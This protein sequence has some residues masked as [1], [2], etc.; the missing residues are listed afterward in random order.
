M[1]RRIISEKR[2]ELG[3]GAAA[4][5]GEPVKTVRH[6]RGFDDVTHE[7]FNDESAEAAHC[8]SCKRAMFESAQVGGICTICNSVICAQCS[9]SRCAICNSCCCDSSA[10]SARM[11]T[12]KV[13]RAHGLGAY[14]KFAFLG[15]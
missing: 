1:A 11:S 15:C 14:L 5:A 7:Q 4:G 8:N 13:C 6:E 3:V 9:E 12:K 10:C 2:T